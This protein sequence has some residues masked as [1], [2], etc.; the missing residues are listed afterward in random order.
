MCCVLLCVVVC[1]VVC[2]CVFCVVVLV[3]VVVVVVSCGCLL[4]C[5]VVVRV[6]FTVVVRVSVVVGLD[7][8][9]AGPSQNFALSLC[10]F[11][12]NFGGLCEDRNP[13]MCTFGLSGCRMKPRRLRDQLDLVAA[14]S[15]HPTTSRN[16]RIST[17]WCTVALWVH[18]AAAQ[19]ESPPLF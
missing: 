10:V 17:V 3:V 13:Q 1:F 4:S 11:S 12:L 5:V 9:S 6:V 8:P 19:Q 16:R 2:C 14:C 18:E 15:H 7:H